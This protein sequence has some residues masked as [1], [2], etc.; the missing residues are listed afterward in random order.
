M[1]K[2]PPTQDDVGKAA[3]VG[4]KRKAHETGEGDKQTAKAEKRAK[5]QQDTKNGLE[6]EQNSSSNNQ[7]KSNIPTTQSESKQGTDQQSQDMQKNGG[8]KFDSEMNS[9]ILIAGEKSEYPDKDPNLKWR[10]LEHR[11]VTFF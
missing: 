8:G 7:N 10:A 3:A 2:N 11:G 4:Q 9:D 6:V 5:T 1:K